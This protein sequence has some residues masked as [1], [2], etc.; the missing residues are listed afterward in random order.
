MR[1]LIGVDGGGTKTEIVVCTTAG[2]IIARLVGPSSNPNDIGKENMLKVLVDLIESS[3]PKDC[4]LADI[5]LGVSGIF[6]ANCEDYLCSCLK[7]RFSFLNK[8]QAYSDKD[9]AFNS[10]YDNDGCIV[11]IGTGSVGYIKKGN[12]EKNIGGG[13]YLIDYALSGFDLGRE[14][15][16]AVLCDNDGIGDKTILSELF[17]NG[18][19]ENIR[20]HL[21][22]VYQKGK[23]Y[24]ASFSPL[25]FDAIEKGDIVAINAMKNCVLGFEKLCLAVYKAW[26]ERKCEI[27]LFGG[28]VNKFD[29]IEKFLSEEIKQNITFKNSKYP[30]IYGLMKNFDKEENFAE[31]FYNNY[32]KLC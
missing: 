3:V 32:I 12:V 28:L 13:G 9:S 7:E 26:G 18:T 23:A 8:V 4:D 27:T 19:K 24:I 22:I 31:V 11:I 29:V 5:G 10:A 1:Y 17:Y 20:K 6:V 16:N 21:K 14:V 15:L 25:I 30:I 2:K